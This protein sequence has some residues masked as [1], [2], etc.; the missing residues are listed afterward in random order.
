MTLGATLGVFLSAD[1]YTTF[2]FFEVMSFTSFVLVIHEESDHAIRAAQTYLAVAVIGGLVTLMGL[3][4]MVMGGVIIWSCISNI[5]ELNRQFAQLEEQGRLEAIVAEFDRAEVLVKGKV[6]L[7][8]NYIFGRG[9]G[10]LV[11]YEDIRQVY[12][13][14]KKRNFAEVV[15]SLKYV[16]RNGKTRDLCELQLRG[17]SDEDVKKIMVMILS[18]N[19]MVKIGYK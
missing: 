6:R 3:F 18:K 10:H 16:D 15:R 13:Y 7:G 2:I 5:L 8:P 9:A 14:V 1:F 17:K 12:Q 11:R 4:M 19:P